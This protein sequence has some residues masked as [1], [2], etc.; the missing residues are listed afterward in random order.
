ML[1]ALNSNLSSLFCRF[2][3]IVIRIDRFESS[4]TSFWFWW[5][6]HTRDSF[7]CAVI[8]D[9][10]KCM[11]VSDAMHPIPSALLF[12]YY[13]FA[14]RMHLPTGKDWMSGLLFQIWLFVWKRHSG[15]SDSRQRLITTCDSK[16]SLAAWTAGDSLQ[17]AIYVLK[18]SCLP[19]SIKNTYS[20]ILFLNCVL[21]RTTELG[22]SRQVN[23]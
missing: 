16:E 1:S 7:C 4:F 22:I 14:S 2:W 20:N 18:Y 13:L 9:D 19:V 3:N 17:R 15:T 10:C 6:H 5:V 12:V 21:F 23:W 11:N 8:W